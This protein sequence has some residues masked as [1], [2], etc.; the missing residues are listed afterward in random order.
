MPATTMPTAGRRLTLADVGAT[1]WDAVTPAGID[2][3][4]ATKALDEWAAVF[5]EEPDFFW[6]PVN[7]VEDLVADPQFRAAGGLVEVPDGV[8]MTTMVN[9]PVDCVTLTRPADS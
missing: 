1:D 4:F 6:A 8:S 5:A 7:S 2:A 3:V 9:T